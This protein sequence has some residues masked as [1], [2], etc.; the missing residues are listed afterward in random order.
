M[1]LRAFFLFCCAMTG[2]FISNG[3]VVINELLAANQTGIQD[4]FFQNED[5]IEIYNS[6]SI[7]NLAGY[8]L[9]DDPLELTK[10]QIPSTN[11]GLTT[12]LPGGH[13]IFW[14]DNDINQ[15]EDHLGFKLSNDG[16]SVVLTM[17]DGMT[18]VDQITYP[19]MQHDISYGRECDGCENWVFFNNLTPGSENM[20]LMQNT[21][22]LY[23]NE[24]LTN[25]TAGIQDQNN[26]YESWFEVYNPNNFQINLSGYYV[27]NTGDPLLFQIPNTDPT[28]TTVPADGF[29]VFWADGEVEEDQNH[30][31][32]SLPN[33]GG[34]LTLSGP[35][36][37]LVDTFEFSELP[38]NTSLGR[39]SDGALT[40]IEFDQPT[41]RVTN[42]LV[43]LEPADVYINEILASN[44]A[45]T[46][47]TAMQFEDWFEIYN[48][49][50]SSVDLAGYWL[51]DNPANP[52]KWQVPF[53]H[54]DSSIIAAGG[55]LLF[56]A[57]EDQSQGWNHVNFRLNSLGEQLSLYSPDGFSVADQLSFSNEQVNISY[58]RETDG[59]SPWVHFTET[60]P[61]YTN[62][63]ADLGIFK[64]QGTRS[65]LVFPNPI[66]EGTLHAKGASS[67][68]LRSVLGHVI[69][70]RQEGNSI[71]I[72]GLSSGIYLLLIDNQYVHRIEVR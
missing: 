43:F 23:I 10:W 42:T 3:Q 19:A 33:S 39:Q 17:P 31:G 60:T 37:A 40:T 35:D 11:P 8:Y 51:S 24:V 15:G 59:N 22:V 69:I 36:G 26:E 46:T 53:D 7:L 72:E 67:M 16:E 70:P 52:M 29:L 38:E 47:D 64:T 48:A 50:S 21:E 2:A 34:A 18:I 13:L 4:D 56:F 55:Y 54:P 25:N 27:S 1:R 63:G 65:F 49:S 44:S 41:P 5:W 32:F 62:N 12:V 71:Q 20:E 28:V 61:E 9:S 68:E 30:V 45:D 14:A 58:G 66:S 57:D 6:G